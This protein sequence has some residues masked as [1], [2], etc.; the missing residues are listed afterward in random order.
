MQSMDDLLLF[1]DAPF[2][3]PCLKKN[4]AHRVFLVYVYLHLIA[5]GHLETLRA[6]RGFRWDVDDP[7]VNWMVWNI[8]MGEDLSPFL[9]D[10]AALHMLD[11]PKDPRDLLVRMG[12]H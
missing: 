5:R 12:I 8:V 10:W 3:H 6:L 11:L 2:K 9:P 7:E 1:A 4:V